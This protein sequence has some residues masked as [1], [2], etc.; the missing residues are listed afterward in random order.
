MT[1]NVHFARAFGFIWKMESYNGFR[2][3]ANIPHCITL[4]LTPKAPVESSMIAAVKITVL[5]P[6]TSAAASFV[7][8]G[9]FSSQHLTR[10]GH[11][12]RR[13]R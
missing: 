9:G 4:Q 2:D 11:W 7:S 5:Q 1:A 3:T 13:C 8:W 12:W 6:A 10:R